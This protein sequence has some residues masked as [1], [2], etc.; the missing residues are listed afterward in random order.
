MVLANKHS[1]TYASFVTLCT[2]HVRISFLFTCFSFP[3]DICVPYSLSPLPSIPL[4]FLSPLPQV[5]GNTSEFVRAVQLLLDNVSFDR[6][7]TTIQV[8]EANIRYAPYRCP[9]YPRELINLPKNLTRP[10][11][12]ITRFIANLLCGK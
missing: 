7:C 3:Y 10:N 8:F 1:D 6:S 11:P 5:M 12:Q 9:N 2:S 4:P